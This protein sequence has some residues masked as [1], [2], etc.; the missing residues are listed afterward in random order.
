MQ[1]FAK[2]EIVCKERARAIYKYALDMYLNIRRNLFEEYMLFEKRYG[3]KQNI[4][5]VIIK[6]LEYEQELIDNFKIM[7]YGWIILN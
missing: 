2:F 4:D 3:D 5:T 7:I 1:L 6:R